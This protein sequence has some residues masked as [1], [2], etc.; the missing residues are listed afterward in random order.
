M[1]HN[2][3]EPINIKFDFTVTKSDDVRRIVEGFLSCSSIDSDGEQIPIEPFV[4][5]MPII[6]K[7][8]GA[9]IEEHSNKICGR[10]LDWKVMD[11]PQTCK[12][13]KEEN[14]TES[15][16]CM[17]GIWIQ[18]EVFK[19]FPTDDECW[20]A[21]KSGEIKG[22]SFGGHVQKYNYECSKEMGG[23][24][25][26]ANGLSVF[27]LSF[28]RRPANPFAY[29][30]NFNKMAKSKDSAISKLIEATPSLTNMLNGLVT[31]GI[32]AGEAKDMVR[33]FVCKSL[34]KFDSTVWIEEQENEI[35]KKAGLKSLEEFMNTCGFC[36]KKLKGLLEKG[37]PEQEAKLQL[38]RLIL[39]ALVHYNTEGGE[40][41]KMAETLPAPVAPAPVAEV[42]SESIVK[43]AKDAV[44]GDALRE[45]KEVVEKLAAKL[46]DV[47]KKLSTFK[48]GAEA[49]PEGDKKPEEKPEEKKPELPKLPVAPAT[50]PVV[51]PKPPAPAPT[52]PPA[53]PRPTAP[54]RKEEA[55]C[56]KCGKEAA[57]CVCPAEVKEETLGAVASNI[58]PE[59]INSN[60]GLDTDKEEEL[61]RREEDL[62]RREADLKR[63][64]EELLAKEQMG[65][66]YASK[67][68]DDEKEKDKKTKK[69]E[70][71]AKADVA[72]FDPHRD[73]TDL[74]V[75]L[76]KELKKIY[77]TYEMVKKSFDDVAKSLDYKPRENQG[78]AV[79]G[80]I[81]AVVRGET[82]L[83][84]SEGNAA[85]AKKDDEEDK[86][87]K[88]KSEDI[89]KA[90]EGKESGSGS[91]YDPRASSDTKET[92]GKVQEVKDDIRVP[93]QK[94]SAVLAA[95]KALK[96]AKELE[97]KL[98]TKRAEVKS[99]TTTP[100]PL[101]ENNQLIAKS[102]QPT[103]QQVKDMS[104][105][106]IED[107]NVRFQ[108]RKRLQQ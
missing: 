29:F 67:K 16:K 15:K 2:V 90:D 66:K 53:E 17:P 108:M 39:K 27:E 1:L 57:V 18:T 58:A 80:K 96:S 19:D 25:N 75:G 105:G 102:G 54:P 24:Y 20:N 52:A 64:E 37:V 30:T 92:L 91:K 38:R 7:R 3:V 61:R 46:E 40:M 70:E 32:P 69:S 100:K 63:K 82:V 76:E 10:L 93:P 106:D 22:F 43:E 99:V 56:P 78:T 89:S 95:R 97:E 23:C 79:L 62:N 48:P 68:D 59:K 87:K 9:M 84:D 101:S 36:Q 50:P 94:L 5:L 73:P 86:D 51:P 35:V 45:L 6:M 85:K 41:K 74:I 107:H 103:L 49:K 104:W 8:G 13:I 34:E 26:K 42:K 71:V 4:Q 55:A 44:V 14:G 11:I 98:K 88:K 28:V 60:V 77:E 31:K 81:E 83:S 21:I 72:K 47:G 65:L 33:C 12:T